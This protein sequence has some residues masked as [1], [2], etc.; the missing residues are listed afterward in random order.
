M[1][2]RWKRL[3]LRVFIVVRS[4][5]PDLLTRQREVI[6]K[7]LELLRIRAEAVVLQW[8]PEVEEEENKDRVEASSQSDSGG[9]A[10]TK[11]NSI[12]NIVRSRG[13]TKGRKFREILGERVG[14]I[15]IFAFGRQQRCLPKAKKALFDPTLPPSRHH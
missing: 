4:N 1:V 5:D 10:K 9:R 15:L 3:H 8:T 11:N 2:P 13:G 12:E 14:G 6:G 7:M